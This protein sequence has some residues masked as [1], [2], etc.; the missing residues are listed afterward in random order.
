MHLGGT[1]NLHHKAVDLSI[2]LPSSS[3]TWVSRN[4]ISECERNARGFIHPE[5]DDREEAVGLVV[6]EKG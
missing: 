5:F 1:L 2:V 3:S 4:A 6:R